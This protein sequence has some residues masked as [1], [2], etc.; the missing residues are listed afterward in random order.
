[1]SNPA[2]IIVKLVTPTADYLK[3]ISNPQEIVAQ[4]VELGYIAAFVRLY[5]ENSV[6]AKHEEQYL[7]NLL[8]ILRHVSPAHTISKSCDQATGDMSTWTNLPE[9]NET[10]LPETEEVIGDYAPLENPVNPKKYKQLL[11][12]LE[13]AKL[14][15]Q[16]I[17]QLLN[18]T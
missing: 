16:L 6:Q 12:A 17:D 3:K 18:N 11:H 2:D 13:S 5:I 10:T 1:M 14:D 7:T 4:L 9:F 15:P 8:Q